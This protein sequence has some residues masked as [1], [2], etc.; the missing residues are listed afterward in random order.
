M[1]KKK[2]LEEMKDIL[3]EYYLKEECE[4]YDIKQLNSKL[5]SCIK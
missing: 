3:L 4:I 5:N 1:I 2:E